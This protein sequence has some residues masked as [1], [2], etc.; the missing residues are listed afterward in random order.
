M[1]VCVFVSLAGCFFCVGLHVFACWFVRV[2]ARLVRFGLLACLFVFLFL[3]LFHF[4]CGCLF[5][6]LFACVL[7]CLFVAVANLFVC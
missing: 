1:C 2:S 7:V 3:C 5:V 6:C 4:L